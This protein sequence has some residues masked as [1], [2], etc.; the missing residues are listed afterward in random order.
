MTRERGILEAVRVAARAWQERGRLADLV[1]PLLDWLL[2]ETHAERAAFFLISPGGGYRARASR[3]L[4]RESI[5]DLERWVSRFAVERALEGRKPTFYADTRQDRRFRT[6]AEVEKGVRT[7]SILAVPVAAQGEIALLYLDARFQPML[8]EPAQEETTGL[9]HDLLAIALQLEGAAGDRRAYERRIRDLERRIGALPAPGAS[10]AATPPPREARAPIDF[11]GFITGHAALIAALEELATLARAKLPI[12]IEGE[13]GTGK[14]VLARAI[15]AAS[16]RKGPFVSIHCGAIPR[17]LIE[18][19]LFGH[20]RGA[21]TGADKA[22]AGLVEMASGGSLFLDEVAEMPVEM[23]TALLRVLETGVYRRV[24]DTEER[25]ADL[26]VLSVTQFGAAEAGAVGEL[27]GDLYYRLAG[28]IVRIPPL[29][30]RPEDVLLLAE[31]FSRKYAPAGARPALAEEVRARML[32]Y[33]WPGNVRELENLVRRFVALGDDVLSLERFQEIA[34]TPPRETEAAGE[35]HRVLDRAE[36]DAIVRA[37]ERASGNKSR[38]AK[39]LGLSRKTL[40]RRLEKHHL[41]S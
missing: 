33:E 24:S 25:S 11:H 12:L 7:R 15:H 20:S 22:R 26:R 39:L 3:N 9:V 17:S 16:G 37:L 31:H 14:D 1:P 18:I 8:W 41:L 21:F 27:R 4:D 10:P 19:E 29:R 5:P 40:Y 35:M 34:G 28:S 30:A 13:S 36:R 2:V 38:A 23:Q 6:E 32:V